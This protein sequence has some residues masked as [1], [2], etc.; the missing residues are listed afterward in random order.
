MFEGIGCLLPIM[1]ETAQPEKM[2][3]LTFGAIWSLAC[4]YVAFSSLC[5]YAWG[6]T[7][8]MPVVTEML[9]SANLLVQVMKLLYCINLIYSYRLNI[10][11]TFTTLEAYLLGVKETNKDE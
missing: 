9:P 10:V 7:L 3:M 6:N 11:P 1:R 8:D 4:V 5:Y 2:P